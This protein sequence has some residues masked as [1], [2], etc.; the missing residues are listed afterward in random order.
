MNTAQAVDIRKRNSLASPLAMKM[1]MFMPMTKK[2]NLVNT[3]THSS[4]IV[5]LIQNTDV[6][7]WAFVC[8][9]KTRDSLLFSLRTDYN[10]I[11]SF[12]KINSL[13]ET[14]FPVNSELNYISG[15]LVGLYNP[16]MR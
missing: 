6:E 12:D 7:K 16:Q 15:G 4:V 10:Q 8:I 5:I 9:L 2:N 11:Q 1:C 3:L 13:G 14:L